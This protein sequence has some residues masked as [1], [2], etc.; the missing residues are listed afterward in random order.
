MEAEQGMGMAAWR[1]VWLQ[2]RLFYKVNVQFLQSTAMNVPWW[3][4]LNG[5][6]VLSIRHV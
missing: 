1:P 5:N 3:A 4:L 6:W 2:Q